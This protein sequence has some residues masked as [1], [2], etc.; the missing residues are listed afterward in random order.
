MPCS[1]TTIFKFGSDLFN[2]FTVT[3]NQCP[4]LCSLHSVEICSHENKG[5]PELVEQA[6][7]FKLQ[8]E[9]ADLIA[10]GHSVRKL[11]TGKIRTV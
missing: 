3:Y 1:I 7:K 4:V 8:F 6:V 11:Y 9:N 5:Y 2:V 10:G